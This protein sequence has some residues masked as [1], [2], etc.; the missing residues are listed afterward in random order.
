M[1]RKGGDEITV[2]ECNSRLNEEER[3]NEIRVGEC[4]SSLVD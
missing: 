3:R 4:N 2:E 1:K